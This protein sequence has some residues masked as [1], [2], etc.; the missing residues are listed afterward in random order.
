MPQKDKAKCP[1]C[2]VIID[3]LKLKEEGTDFVNESVVRYGSCDLDGDSSEIDDSE[4]TDSDTRDSETDQVF[5]Y[6]PECEKEISLDDI[7]YEDDNS[8]NSVQKPQ[9]LRSS[10]SGLIEKSKYCYG[11]NLIFFV[12]SCGERLE[13]DPE[14][15]KSNEEIICFH[16]GKSINQKTAKSVIKI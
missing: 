13:A 10:E 14:D 1:H 7:V 5:Y 16:C 6:C 15:G 4:C 11:I 2:G 12:C 9:P 8:Q 3:H